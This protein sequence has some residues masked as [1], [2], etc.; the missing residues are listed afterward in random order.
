LFMKKRILTYLKYTLYCVIIIIVACLGLLFYSGNSVKYNRN[1]SINSDSLAG[2]G[3]YIVYQH[4]QV[5]QVYLK[6]SKAE[7]YAID[8]KIVQDSIVEVHVN[9]YPDQ[10]YF[11]VQLPIYQHFKPEVAVY[12]EPEKLLVISDIEGGFSAFRNLLIANGVMNETYQWTY[13]KGHV[14]L[15]G[16]F[17][18]R[19]YFVT[20]VLYLIFHLE[21]QAQLAGGKV[22]YILGNHEI[23]NMQGDHSY[24]AG[25]YAYAATLLGIQQAELY[26]G[27]KTFLSR[28]LSSKNTMVKI[29][30][31]LIVH[32][33]LHL[34]FV[35]VDFNIDSINQKVRSSY[36]HMPV[37]RKGED[38][39]QFELLHSFHKSHYWYRGYFKESLDEKDLD[40]LLKHIACKRI[41]VGHTVQS[42]VKTLY[43]GRIVAVDVQHR[44]EEWGSYFPEA[45]AQA[46]LIEQSTLYRVDLEGEKTAL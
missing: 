43:G 20:Q 35:A 10:S 19:G 13:G 15:A 39:I 42:K 5:R 22:Y 25:K 24:A 17:V 21:Q 23:M 38:K 41:I 27:D 16:D 31:N 9:Y 34:D 12:P 29:G 8:E 32:A 2:E 3:P 33:G 40:K 30:D 45:T 46:L 4:D 28:W 37:R 11:K 36:T 6:G 1:H 18:D 14:A 44:Q 26:A 7:G